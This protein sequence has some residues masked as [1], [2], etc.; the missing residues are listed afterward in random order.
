MSLQTRL[1]SFITA[2]GADIKTL[3]TQ[4]A[5]KLGVSAKAADSELLDGLDS[6][7]YAKLS[8]K[9]VLGWG[10]LDLH[11][12]HTSFTTIDRFGVSYVQGGTGGPGIPGGMDQYYV[13][14]MSLGSEY[15]YS[16]YVYQVA[17][18]RGVA[19]VFASRHREAGTWSAWVI[20]TNVKVADSELLDG[21]NS[22][23]FLRTDITQTLD[24]GTP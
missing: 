8:Q 18:K 9:D 4:M 16:A 24:G 20:S 11:S 13:Y 5:G 7:A 2:V 22:T 19:G 10:Q 1:Q 12:T 17:Y 6:T 14:S 15:A 21:L 23:A 3:N